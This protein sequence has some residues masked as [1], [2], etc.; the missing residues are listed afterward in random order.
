MV[1]REDSLE[2]IHVSVDTAFGTS[3]IRR[4]EW[5]LNTFCCMLLGCLKKLQKCRSKSGSAFLLTEFS[6]RSASSNLKIQARNVAAVANNSAEGRREQPIWKRMT[7]PDWTAPPKSSLSRENVTKIHTTNRS[8]DNRFKGK[9][10][11]EDC[12]WRRGPHFFLHWLPRICQLRLQE[13][14]TY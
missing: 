10:Q 2:K 7:V 14:R 8:R 13:R 11:T 5:L 3:T 1:A 12:S 4:G 6:K 9:K